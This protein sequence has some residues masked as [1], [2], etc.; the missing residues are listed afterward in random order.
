MIQTQL[1][2]VLRVIEYGHRNNDSEQGRAVNPVRPI[3]NPIP[4]NQRRIVMGYN[5]TSDDEADFG[6]VA[7][8]RGRFYDGRQ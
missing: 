8:A 6:E 4:N 1:Q 3:I 2:A 5:D 7:N